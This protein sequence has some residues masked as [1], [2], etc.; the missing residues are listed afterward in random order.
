MTDHGWD[1]QPWDQRVVRKRA[2]TIGTQV[3]WRGSLM[4]L[5]RSSGVGPRHAVPRSLSEMPV[6]EI[7]DVHHRLLGLRRVN[8]DVILGVRLSFI[9]IEVGFDAGS[10]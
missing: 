2:S 7:C 3:I 9:D 1:L 10:T 4:S 8:V 5:L 6:Q